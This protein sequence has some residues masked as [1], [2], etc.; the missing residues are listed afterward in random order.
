MRIGYAQLNTTVGDLEVNLALGIDAY[1]QLSGRGV[2]LVVFPELFLCGYP[3]KDLLHK[4]NFLSDVKKKLDE[5][6]VEFGRKPSPLLKLK[7]VWI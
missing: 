1:E 7:N 4:E 6:N 3:P 2:D 5:L